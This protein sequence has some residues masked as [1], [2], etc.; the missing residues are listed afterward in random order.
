MNLTRSPFLRLTKTTSCPT[1]CASINFLKLRVFLLRCFS[2]CLRHHPNRHANGSTHT[3]P[4]T[5]CIRELSQ[6]G[7]RPWPHIRQDHATRISPL[8]GTTTQ[9]LLTRGSVSTGVLHQ[10][11][12][13]LP[14]PEMPSTVANYSQTKEAQRYLESSDNE[15]WVMQP[16]QE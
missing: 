13:P 1:T 14:L 5:S 4:V 15:Q 16:S 11:S 6:T 3:Q 2:Q 12:L 8:A 10:S 9:P 7:F